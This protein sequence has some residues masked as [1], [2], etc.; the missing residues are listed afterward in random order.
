MS[1]FQLGFILFFVAV[2]VLAIL[3]FSGLI[4]VGQKSGQQSKDF[5]NLVLWGTADIGKVNQVLNQLNEEYKDQFKVNYVQKA[6]ASLELDFLRSVASGNTPD[7]ILFP[8]DLLYSI[9]GQLFTIP[10]ESIT[11]RQFRDLFIEGAEIYIKSDG[12]SAIPILVDPL[13]MYWNRDLFNNERVTDIPKNWNE[14]LDISRVLTKKNNRQKILQSAVAL[15]GSSNINHFKDILSLLLI[16][17]GDSIVQRDSDMKNAYI[18]FGDSILNTETSVTPAESAILFYTGFANP[19]LSQYSW[20]T[21]FSS[22]LDS[23]ISGNLAIY[24]GPA[25]D[26]GIIKARNPHLNFDVA[27]V[28]QLSNTPNSLSYGKF[29]ALG[30]TKLSA[31]VGQ[32]F[33]ALFLLTISDNKYQIAFSDSLSLPP[34]KRILLTKGST[35]PFISIFY[36]EAPI[37]RSWIDPNPS[38]TNKIFIKLLNSV[39]S[40][41]TG[42][43]QVIANAKV[44]LNELIKK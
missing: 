27:P 25:S 34:V 15:G 1:K 24:F 13:I 23:F 36:S 33:K 26:F 41:S 38:E 19:K 43:S 7:L 20:N 39:L 22:S 8:N 42:I 30:V 21:S 11:Q 32:A 31:N 9:E 4:D 12:I 3:I 5:A 14:I 35:D 6:G 40:K 16:Q 2:G 10:E 44:Q 17:S 18:Y 37:T 28:P 29:Y